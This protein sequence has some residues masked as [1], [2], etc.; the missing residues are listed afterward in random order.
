[1]TSLR[2]YLIRAIY[3][4]ILDNGCTPYI[5]VNTLAEGVSVPQQYVQPDGSIVL[6]LRPEAVQN[7]SLGDDYI[8]FSARFGGV[9]RRLSVAVTAV[10]AIYAMENGR[11][12]VFEPEEG[13][14][15]PPPRPEPESKRPAKPSRPVLTVVK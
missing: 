6:N 12:M 7:L 1:M 13:A 4:W 9:P 11:G 2:P 8:E 3:D 5:L 10:N 14:E 15:P